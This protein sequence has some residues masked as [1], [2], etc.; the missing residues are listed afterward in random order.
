MPSTDRD[1]RILELRRLVQSG[2]YQVDPQEVATSIIRKSEKPE[3]PQTI[4][5][6]KAAN[7]A[8]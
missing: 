3:K 6:S 5:I 2:E 7:T 4:L 8:E 1:E